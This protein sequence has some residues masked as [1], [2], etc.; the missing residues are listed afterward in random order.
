MARST[1]RSILFAMMVPGLIL[2]AGCGAGEEEPTSGGAPAEDAVTADARLR[3][4]ADE[5]AHSLLIVDTHVDVP[6]RLEEE[7]EDISGRTAKGDFDFPRAVAGGLNV[8]FMSIY[9]PAEKE[10]AGG[11]KDL[12]EKLIAMVEKF[13][14]EWPDKF[15]VAR[16]TADVRAAVAAGKIALPMG[17]ENGAPIEGS[18]ENLRHFSEEGIRYIT[19]SHSEN[20]H[21][22]DSSYAETER[23]GGLSPFGREVVSEMNRL[24]VMIDISHVSDKSA[25]QVLD[26]T[27][28][29]VIASHSSCR[30]FTPGW[31]RNISD[32]LIGR[33][34]EN[35]GVV[36][37][38]FGSAF[39]DEAANSQST[40]F[41]KAAKEF[42]ES[43]GLEREDPRVKAFEEEYFKAAPK[44]FADLS[45]VINNIDH[46]VSLAGIDHVGFGSDFDGVGDSLPEGLKDVT[47]YPNIIY[48]LLKRGYSEE[49]IA[50]ICGEN[51]MRVWS[52]VEKAADPGKA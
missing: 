14:T 27:K 21:L 4:R 51:L 41:W 19:L 34:A 15:A 9:V 17:M 33:V 12:A 47:G 16:S 35:G 28:A 18:L 10:T 11:A 49:D 3:A 38:N 30:R 31:Q 44:I 45:D 48:E 37:I 46:V 50:K 13:E 36:M 6:Y 32:E 24:G 20:N 42:R 26:L 39:L 25:N 29:P 43:N 23:W 8:P 1:K 40:A 7:M 22:C 52:E 2:L 5:L